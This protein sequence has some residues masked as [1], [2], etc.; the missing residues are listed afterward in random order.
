MTQRFKAVIFDLDGTLLDTLED[1]A[2][3]LNSVLR[4]EG[5]PVHA[6]DAYRFMVGNGLETLV[7]RALPEGLRIPAH[8]R[9]I[10]TKF[11]ERYRA[12]QAAK[13]TPYPGVAETLRELAALGLKLAVLSNK[14]HPNTLSVVEHYF[15]GVFQEIFGLRPEVPP[16][17]H[18]AGALEI[19]ERLGVAPAEC[20]YLGDSNV[21]M[22]T[23]V[24]AGMYAVGAAWG[25][26]PPK[27]LFSAGAEEVIE[28]PPVLLEI[29][30]EA[31]DEPDENLSLSG[32]ARKLELG[33]LVAEPVAWVTQRP[34][35]TDRL[36]SAPGRLRLALTGGIASGKSTV[37]EM[38]VARG[39]GHID[40]DILARRAVA[41]G[42]PGFDE[43]VALFGPGILKADGDLDRPKISRAIFSDPELKQKL[44]AIIH[45]RAWEL[46][47]E[48]LAA[49]DG[50]AAVVVS[51][52]LLFEGGL[53]RFFSPIVLV[54]AD[55]ETQLTRL[56]A[57]NPELDRVAAENIL[58]AQWPAPPK[59]MGSSYV[60]NNSGSREDTARQV[61]AIWKAL[62]G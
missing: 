43:T 35:I 38:L 41:P 51:L 62:G 9:P 36:V 21:D 32:F 22:E 33:R 19:A 18:P 14:A 5:L 47:G 7:V 6:N 46:M 13:T 57:R 4:D 48:D 27:E 30:T 2:D 1:I 15:P 61:D 52:P 31:E 53:E 58:A 24:A 37:A 56:L 45:P 34:D 40:F 39:A 25:F 12:N 54:F 23:A 55:P 59:V 10:F 49:M 29:V 3:S 16:K 42:S 26:R 44:E 20:L 60:I 17:P 8:V 50:K 28:T 11:V